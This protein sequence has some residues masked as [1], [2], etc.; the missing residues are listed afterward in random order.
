MRQLNDNERFFIERMPKAELHVHLEGSIYPETLLALSDK[1]GMDLPFGDLAG[2][3]DWFTFRDFPHFIEVYVTTCDFLKDEEDYEFIT[4]EMARRA[5]EQNLQYMEITYAPT[6]ILYPRNNALPDMV[7]A[8]IRSGA[9]RAAAEYGVEMQF[10]L[11]P[12]RGRSVE[13]VMALAEWCANNLGDRLVGIGLGGLEVGNPASRFQDAFDLARASGARVS[14]HAGETVGPESVRDALQTGTDR[15]GHGVRSAEDPALVAELAEIGM[16]LEVSPTSNI[17]LGVAPS[18][19]EHPI[20]D[21]YDAGVQVTVNSDDPPMFNTTLTNEYLVLAEQFGFSLD[22]LSALSL[23]AVDA[24]FLPPAQKA[25]MRGRFE[26]ELADLSRELL[27]TVD[28]D[29]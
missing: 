24:A 17:C 26:Q 15:I 4:L 29:D 9:N 14:L 3:R 12:V 13:E 28:V 10:I 23:G 22:E 27:S 25:A 21:L 7:T 18:Y 5:A 6:S 16:V 1:H 11:D 19:A 2:A 8:G 20:R